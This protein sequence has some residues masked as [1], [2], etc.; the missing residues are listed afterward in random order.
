MSSDDFQDADDHP[1][2]SEGYRHPDDISLHELSD[3]LLSLHLLGDDM[4]LR[5]QANNLALID[6]FI[7]QHETELLQTYLQRER[8][9]IEHATFV[10]AQSQMWIFAAYE[11]LRTWRQRAKDSIKLHENGGL[12][13]KAKALEQDQGYFHLGKKA[14]AH[15]LRGLIADPT[16]I[17]RLRA[18]LRLTHIPFTRMEYIRV[19]LAKHE[20]SGKARSIAYAPG[21]GRINMFCGALE[22]QMSNGPIIIGNISRRD[23]ADEIRA[24]SDRA[25]IP[26]AED[27][28]S[29]DESMN[30]PANPF[31]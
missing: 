6:Q 18:E 31:E 2:P 25:Y 24:L 29:F 9:P 22:Y 1:H 16:L 28:K 15:Q 8:T 12:V 14:R 20:V 7:M 13:P 27:L 10:S 30:P 11:L 17:A 3:A 21:Y 26:S 23:I 4:F 5:M 19:A